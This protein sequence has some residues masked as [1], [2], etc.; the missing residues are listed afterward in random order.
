MPITVATVLSVN[1]GRP[2]EFDFNGRPAKSA[3]WKSP[4]FQPYSCFMVS[5]VHL[6]CF[7]V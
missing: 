7:V 5:R 3:I 2:R 6:T 4:A 1:V